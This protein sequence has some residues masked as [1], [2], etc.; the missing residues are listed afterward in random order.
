MGD[1]KCCIRHDDVLSRIVFG[2]HPDVFTKMGKPVVVISQTFCFCKEHWLFYRDACL[3][4]I[5]EACG[6]DIGGI[7]NSSTLAEGL[8]CWITLLGPGGGNYQ[9]PYGMFEGI[10]LYFFSL[11]HWTR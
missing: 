1:V 5:A 11:V 10:Y 2:V 8:G 4:L 3:C 7:S 9:L 6:G